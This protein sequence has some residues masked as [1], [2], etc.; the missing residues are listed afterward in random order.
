MGACVGGCNAEIE[1][2]EDRVTV[3]R[4]LMAVM[5]GVR[6]RLLKIIKVVISD[7]MVIITIIMII[8]RG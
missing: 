8:I 7:V 6:V 5:D 2:K 4:I 3:L 1:K